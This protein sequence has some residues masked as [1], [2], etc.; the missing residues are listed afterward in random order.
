MQE[1]EEE[2]EGGGEAGGVGRIGMAAA[3]VVVVTAGGAAVAAWW[4]FWWRRWRGKYA[5]PDT[6]LSFDD[7][8]FYQGQFQ[9]QKPLIITLCSSVS[10]HRLYSLEESV[11]FQVAPYPMPSRSHRRICPSRVIPD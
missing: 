11:S 8:P 1:W 2:G 3:V 6:I 10:W 7:N 5:I 9:V 4:W